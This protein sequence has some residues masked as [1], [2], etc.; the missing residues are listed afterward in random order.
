MLTWCAAAFRLLAPAGTEF[1]EAWQELWQKA[2]ERLAAWL[3]PAVLTKARA[4]MATQLVL[5]LSALAEHTN[6]NFMA[7]V[8]S[9]RG[10][11]L[12]LLARCVTA[13]VPRD[14]GRSLIT[15]GVCCVSAGV[16]PIVTS[17]QARHPGGTAQ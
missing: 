14:R 12:R 7:G 6:A 5:A 8:A 15:L 16:H 11:L 10:L 13:V 9:T 3:H 4:H 17:L 2:V 1:C